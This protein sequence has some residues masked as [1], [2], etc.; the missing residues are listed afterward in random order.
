MLTGN[1]LTSN[2]NFSPYYRTIDE[3][4]KNG[5]SFTN[6]ID[7]HRRIQ[8][9]SDTT[10]NLNDDR[11][12][13]PPMHVRDRFVYVMK[14]DNVLACLPLKCGTTRFWFLIHFSKLQ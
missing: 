14:Y 3:L 2:H 8:N 10:W 13:A 6:L 9:L 12:C 11:E 1:S 7:F 4:S 5:T